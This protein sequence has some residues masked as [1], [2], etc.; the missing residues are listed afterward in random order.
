[1]SL[2]IQTARNMDSLSF[3]S[4]LEL[5]PTCDRPAANLHRKREMTCSFLVVVFAARLVLFF[6]FA[7]G[8]E[9]PPASTI[10]IPSYPSITRGVYYFF[11][12]IDERKYFDSFFPDV[13][14]V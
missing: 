14:Q 8:K 12:S 1:M 3:S 9:A 13:L 7:G 4:R 6:R 11:R 5:C 2:P 10:K